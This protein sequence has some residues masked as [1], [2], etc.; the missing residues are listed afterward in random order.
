MLALID[1]KESG[2]EDIVTAPAPP[3][4]EKVVDLMAAP[5][6][7]VKDAKP[8]KQKASAKTATAKR[9]SATR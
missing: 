6:A 4:A 2:Q 8:A 9:R 5:E 1:R 3:A 7:S